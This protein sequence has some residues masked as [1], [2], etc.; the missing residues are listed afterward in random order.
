MKIKKYIARNMPEALRQVREDLGEGAIILNTR[1]LRRNNRFNLDASPC[2]EVTAAF[3]S[4]AEEETPKTTHP[5]AKP[6]PNIPV[7][8]NPI[9]IAEP[10]A[11]ESASSTESLNV[12]DVMENLRELRESVA[13]VERH[14]S[15]KLVLP[16]EM[17]HLA[18]RLT[19]M[20]MVERIVSD[21]LQKILEGLS[22]AALHDARQL[23]E[24][25]ANVLSVK[26]PLCK[27][28][29]IGNKRKVVALFGPPGAGKTTA[30]AKI[31]AGFALKRGHRIVWVTTDD[32]HVGALDQ[33]KAFV[34]IIGVPLEIA[35]SEAEMQAVL[36]HHA[37]AQLILIDPPG[38]GAGQTNECE[39]QRR[40]FEAAGVNEVQLVI[41]SMIGTDHMLDLVEASCDFPGRRLL[42]TKLD[43]T[44]RPGA[45]VSVAIQSGIPGSYFIMG[46]AVPGEIEAGDFNKLIAKIVG[47][48]PDRR[49]KR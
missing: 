45:A 16:A 24:K 41:D 32:Q 12:A 11:V 2:V 44:S 49:K 46:S 15:A 14:S 6:K 5:A 7:L 30:A 3:D 19:S 38:C 4:V 10:P 33:S 37:D 21:V 47:A 25:A 1:Q 34:Q 13:R 22:G 20:G 36:E 35:H 23:A 9:R 27:D 40:L 28:I 39:R 48:T 31:A 43:Q 29:R 17:E 8:G 26:A 18:A 42:F